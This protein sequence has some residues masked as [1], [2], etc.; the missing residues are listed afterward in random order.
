MAAAGA[1]SRPSIAEEG[2]PLKKIYA[3]RLKLEAADLK[4]FK[5]SQRIFFK[6]GQPL[7]E[8]DILKQP[9]LAKTYRAL[10][11]HGSDW[12]Y[13]GPF[14]MATAAWMQA[15]GG[16]MTARDFAD[17]SIKLRE[18][19]TTDYRGYKVVTFSPPSSGGVHLLEMLNT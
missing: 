14:A 13:R 6:D 4:K 1:F 3:A 17:Y 16:I 18:P 9:D 8:G 15:H 10:A 7:K 12:F 11:E 19:V 2:F 5:D